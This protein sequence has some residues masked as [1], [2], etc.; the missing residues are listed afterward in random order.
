M[1]GEAVKKLTATMTIRRSGQITVDTMAGTPHCGTKDKLDIM[2]EVECRCTS[3]SIDTNGFLFDQIN[4]DKYFQTIEAVSI[5]CER[6]TLK[7][8]RDLLKMVKAE[9]PH[10]TILQLKVTL[11]P[12]PFMAS[13]TLEIGE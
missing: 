7:T 3:D 2:Y 4:I 6:L 5:S 10:C 13:I 1:A 12:E 11:S 8:A 9:N